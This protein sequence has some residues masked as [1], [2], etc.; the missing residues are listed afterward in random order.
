MGVTTKRL[1]FKKLKSNLLNIYIYLVSH[2]QILY[3]ATQ[4]LYKL[5]T[6]EPKSGL[7]IKFHSF[8]PFPAVAFSAASSFSALASATGSAF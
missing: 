2:N 1:T 4:A 7:N 8:I 3:V 6:R 5:M